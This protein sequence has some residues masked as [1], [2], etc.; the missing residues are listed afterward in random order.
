MVRVSLQVEL[1]RDKGRAGEH[2]GYLRSGRADVGRRHAEGLLDAE[3]DDR[4]E[5]LAN[6][7]RVR[8][9]KDPKAANVTNHLVV[10]HRENLV[11]KLWRDALHA[12]QRGTAVPNG[13]KASKPR[14]WSWKSQL[15]CGRTA[16]S[17]RKSRR[18][19]SDIMAPTREP[20]AA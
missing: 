13:S 11:D 17:T 2:G 8:L 15:Y 5:E 7:A 14:D 3:G 20:A 6:H 19:E 12:E 1:G 16:S 9:G 10:A 18:V 4:L